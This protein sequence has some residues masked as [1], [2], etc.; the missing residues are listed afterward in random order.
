MDDEAATQPPSTHPRRWVRVGLAFLLFALAATAIVWTQRNTIAELVIQ[1]AALAAGFGPV[2][3]TV[4]DLGLKSATVADIT[5][6]GAAGQRIG[7]LQAGYTLSGLY[8]GTIE[9]LSVRGARLR[10]RIGPDGPV[11]AGIPS[12]KSKDTDAPFTVPV[13][14]LRFTT[15]QVEIATPNGD[16]VV[17]ASGNI[18]I[19]DGETSD[20]ESDFAIESVWGAVKGKLT[21]TRLASSEIFG[22]AALHDGTGSFETIHATGVHGAIQFL[23]LGN[24]KLELDA[25]LYAAT[26]AALGEKLGAARAS[27]GVREA[28]E[29]NY[30][31]EATISGAA[32]KFD[33]AGKIDSPEGGNPAAAAAFEIDL[34]RDGFQV[35]AIGES[36]FSLTDDGR[37][38]TTLR[39]DQAGLEYDAKTISGI[40]GNAQIER[41]PDGAIKGEADLTFQ[42]FAAPGIDGQPGSLSAR[43]DEKGMA[44]HAALDWNDGTLR[45]SANG[46]IDG[47]VQFKTEGKLDSVRSLTKRFAGVEAEGAAAFALDGSVRSPHEVLRTA[48]SEPLSVLFNLDARGWLESAL[49]NV[50]LPGIARGVSLTGRTD[51]DLDAD[52]LRIATGELRLITAAL[53]KAI[54]SV[55]PKTVRNHFAAP[56]RVMIGPHGAPAATFRITPEETGHKVD[57]RAVLTVQTGNA[58]F[59]LRGRLDAKLDPLGHIENIHTARSTIDLF[60]TEPGYGKVEFQ[61]TLTDFRYG[62]RRLAGK[63]GLEASY[64]GTVDKRLAPLAAASQ[65]S[66]RISMNG[67]RLAL[68]VASGGT[69]S[70]EEIELPDTAKFAGPVTATLNAPMQASIDVAQGISTLGYDARFDLSAGTFSAKAGG[71]W[72]DAEHSRIPV[73][74]SGNGS[75]HHFNAKAEAFEVATHKVRVSTIEL[76][77][78]LGKEMSS[79]L[80]A[81]KIEHRGAPAFFTP[82]RVTAAMQGDGG[83]LTFNGRLFDPPERISVSFS[84]HHNPA[85]DS[86]E[87]SIDARKLTFLPT[88]LQPVQLFPVL[89]STLREV[90]GEIDAL[91]MFAWRGETF[92]SSLD[93]LVNAKMIKADEFK[94]E[95]AATVVRFDSLLPPSTP[96]KQEV[97]IGLLDIGV[98][99]LNGRLEFQ[100]DKNGSVRAALRELDFF[101][102]RVETPEFTI[103]P[104]F[105][106]FNVPLQVNGVELESLLA[107]A[108]SGDLAATGTLNGSIPVTIKE[109]EVAIRNGVLESA[110][111][112]GSIRYRPKAVGPSLADANEGMKLFLQIVDDFQYNKVKVTFD[113]DEQD[114]VAF[115][116]KIEGRNQAVYKGI[117]VELNVSMDGPLRK[118]LSQGL[119]TY[120]LPARILSEM[121]RFEDRG[122]A[123]RNPS[124]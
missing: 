107:L 13:R 98:P 104:T 81:D 1:R 39:F 93:L 37:I 92:D 29:T 108:Q 101:G 71:G 47:P 96:P 110:A 67:G 46:P 80:K 3:L 119:K 120:K 42:R 9:S 54:I 11:F 95:N 33:V 94:F 117:P 12:G 43:L 21:A 55:L 40:S 121:K 64:D 83:R 8:R 16:V 74:A 44:L 109:G 61:C 5:I 69:I 75:G 123:T 45:V 60:I 68:S 7:Q 84:G 97:S 118:I 30:A 76:D 48:A 10:G 38:K 22:Q 87:I 58:E 53:D 86:G 34:Q 28:A 52:G 63:F 57:G 66:G 99:M 14:D 36:T 112:G 50:T 51:I 78:D 32:G 62:E 114:E 89:G 24:R 4:T 26:L 90:D 2:T 111:G 73:I 106:G 49:S 122:G 27:I 59:S 77:F 116:F 82:L 91:A 113:E 88:V 41:A 85:A 20:L 15:S 25:N 72:I 6:G 100:L 115:R 70:V 23:V 124:N 65:L 18:A 79:T 35:E 102:G 56:I 17:T 103:P 31:I 105:D 19:P